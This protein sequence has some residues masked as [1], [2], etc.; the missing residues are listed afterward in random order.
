MES[1]SPK[2]GWFNQASASPLLLIFITLFGLAGG[3]AYI[4][5][6]LQA[7][8]TGETRTKD[9]SSIQSHLGQIQAELNA[10]D[11]RMDEQHE[12]FLLQLEALHS[13]Y[14][15]SVK[16]ASNTAPLQTD[17]YEI[18]L[19]KWRHLG[20]G[21]NKHGSYA[22]LHDGQQTV[23]LNKNQAVKGAWRLA[24]FNSSEAVLLGPNE[25]RIVLP[26]Q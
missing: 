13:K 22:L 6:Q 18:E 11:E 7:L 4:A 2:Q 9:Y 12:S 1:T 10:L 5:L 23:M 19:K 3:L 21:Q 24:D 25:K 20:I 8:E 14:K 17:A 16:L 26:I 15:G